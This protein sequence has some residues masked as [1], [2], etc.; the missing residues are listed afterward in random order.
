MSES[1]TPRRGVTGA[2]IL[3]LI[4]LLVIASLGVLPFWA[5]PPPEEGLPDLV[6][7]FGRFHPVVL[8]LP[9]GMLLLV[10]LLETGRLFSRKKS[11]ASTL[12][13]MFFAAA[14]AV[15]ATLL[16]FL[17]YYSMP[18]YNKELA[19]RHLYGGIIFACGTVAAFI[20]KLWVD[21]A[22]GRGAFLYWL[23]LLGSTGVMGFASHDGASLTH[24]KDYLDRKST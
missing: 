6:K 10:L 20:V 16:G 5:G 9:I 12:I 22:G 8:H 4:G 11:G 15:V 13:A 17:L 7:F 19:E 18:D 24:G 14:S 3:T 23:L 21:V 2:V 1:E